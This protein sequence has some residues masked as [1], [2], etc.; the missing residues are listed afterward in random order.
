MEPFLTP[1]AN[2]LIKPILVS[3]FKNPA[4]A[5]PLS[6]TQGNIPKLAFEDQISVVQFLESEEQYRTQNLGPKDFITFSACL[7]SLTQIPWFDIVT[8]LP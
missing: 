4:V 3:F 8:T 5:H 6:L 7:H 1:F 2:P